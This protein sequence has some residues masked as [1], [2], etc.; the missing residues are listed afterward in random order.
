MA[1]NKEMLL[2]QLSDPAAKTKIAARFGG[3]I[4][5]RLRESS[6]AEQVLPPENVDRSQCQVSTQ[7]DSLVK[8]EYLEP[9]SRAMTV[10]FRGEPRANFIRGEKVEVP[11]IT[12]MSDMFQKPE[13][14]FL[15]YAFPIGKVIEQ[16]AVRDL[17]EVQDREFLIHIEAA[18]QALQTEANGGTP[19]ALNPTSIVG[20]AVEF[21]ITKGE[22]ARAAVA[23]FTSVS[24]PI[25]RPD[26]VRLI[27]LLDGNR[28]ESNMIL[29]TTVD[30]D[31][32]LAWTVEDQGD[33][34]QSE[35]AVQGWK[36]NLLLGKRYVR[37]VKTDILRP[38]NVYC[39]TSPDFLGKFYVLN[40]VKFYIDKYINLIKFVA[41]KDIGMSIINIASV[42]KL[43]LYSGD[44]N[45][46]TNSD[47]ILGSVTPAAEEDLGRPN[48]R[49][50]NRQFFPQVVSIG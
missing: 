41:W 3:Y 50:G 21:S 34:L 20:G 31:D 14:E 12:V 37:T 16:N 33:K 15:A 8:I 19:T 24:L 25:Q 7:H 26:I 9:R 43:E 10:T 11:F 42:R 27:K 36:Y 48:N 46:S 29:I 38:G 35:T 1:S 47:A 13:Q 39:F 18:C 5:D 22:L 4:R 30:W 2:N 17:G 32:I 40:N 6:F 44:A 49:A 45:P 28:L 23:P